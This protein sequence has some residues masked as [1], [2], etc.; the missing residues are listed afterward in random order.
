VG[1]CYFYKMYSLLVRSAFQLRE[2]CSSSVGRYDVEI[3]EGCLSTNLKREVFSRD[4]RKISSMEYIVK[5][6][7]VA[8]F[9]ICEGRRIV[10]EPIGQRQDKMIRL[11]LLGPIFNL[12]LNQNGGLLIHA[13]CLGYF[14]GCFVLAAPSGTGKS[15]L[16]ATFL[17]CEEYVLLA[18]DVCL[19]S[20]SNAGEP[21]IQPAYPRLK[22]LP[23]TI[24]R[25]EFAREVFERISSEN[26]KYNVLVHSRFQNK[27]L[28]LKNIF[29]LEEI[30]CDSIDIK[31]LTGKAK[32]SALL[33]NLYW[34]GDQ[35]NIVKRDMTFTQVSQL[36]AYCD[37][38]IVRFSKKNH[39]PSQVVERIIDFL[40]NCTEQ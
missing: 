15:T 2:C 24:G 10:V 22:L 21:I 1:E 37:V 31:V 29:I 9:Q 26:S 12:L 40:N 7:G 28:P 33:N 5:I 20:Y 4:I 35:L 36:V 17:N 25:I 11:Y 6:E 13:S 39:V 27:A 19:V 34:I 32:I 16:A 30:A 18:D 14:N 23:D 3:S 38:S 8:Y